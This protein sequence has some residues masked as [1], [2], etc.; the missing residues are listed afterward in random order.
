MLC[1]EECEVTLGM[2]SKCAWALLARLQRCCTAVVTVL[3]HVS[4]ESMAGGLRG[5][6]E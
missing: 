2:T 4:M 5:M 1:P 3:P 6:R